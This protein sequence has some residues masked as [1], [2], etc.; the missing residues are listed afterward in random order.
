M[1]THPDDRPRVVSRPLGAPMNILMS[2]AL[3]SVVVAAIVL[4]LSWSASAALAALAWLRARRRPRPV[5]IE[6]TRASAIVVEPRVFLVSAAHEDG[7]A[8]AFHGT[9]GTVR[10][11]RRMGYHVAILGVSNE[12]V[13]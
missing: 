11:Y 7:S 13:T 8:S 12:T 9:M 10:M 4:T 5:P 2:M 1:A 3:G 6:P